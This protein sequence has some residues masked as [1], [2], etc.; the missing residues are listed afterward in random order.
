MARQTANAH[1]PKINFTARDNLDI[2]CERNGLQIATYLKKKV[3]KCNFAL[4][5]L[6]H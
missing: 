5:L 2:V 4:F 3:S 6:F 1:I